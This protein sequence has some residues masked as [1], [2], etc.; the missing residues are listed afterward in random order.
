MWELHLCLPLVTT[1]EYH[2][3]GIFSRPQFGSSAFLRL[4]QLLLAYSISITIHPRP[5]RQVQ[6]SAVTVCQA[7][8]TN[9][10]PSIA[11]SPSSRR[12]RC[13]GKML[14]EL[15]NDNEGLFLFDNNYH[16]KCFIGRWWCFSSPLEILQQFTRRSSTVEKEED[17]SCGRRRPMCR[18]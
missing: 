10:P 14:P 8:V 12:W 18:R 2:F 6:W 16:F 9:H 3:F 13:H 17:G 1:F 7:L 15:F 5:I 11:P 4:T